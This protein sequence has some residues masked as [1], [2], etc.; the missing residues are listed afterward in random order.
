M[1]QYDDS[2]SGHYKSKC[3]YDH[4]YHKKSND[5]SSSHNKLINI[6]VVGLGDL[7]D[8]AVAPTVAAPARTHGAPGV[9]S[10][11]NG[12]GSSYSRSSSSGNQNKLINVNVVAIDDDTLDAL[13]AK[14]AT[15]TATARSE[16][17]SGLVNNIRSNFTCRPSDGDENKLININLVI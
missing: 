16:R 5:N 14:R 11:T 6:N 2:D 9:P 4:K 15:E 1:E 7:L 13:R 8:G 12:N 10:T 17:L 3:R